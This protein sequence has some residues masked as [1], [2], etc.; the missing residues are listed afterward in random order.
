MNLLEEIISRKKEEIDKKRIDFPISELIKTEEFKKPTKSLGQ[1][2]TSGSGIIAE[3]KHKSPTAGI[4]DNGLGLNDVLDIYRMNEV[5]GVS[6]L[7]DEHYFGGSLE[8]LKTAAAFEVGPVLRKDFIVDEYQIFEAKAYGAD[9]ILLIAEAL[10]EYHATY[11]TTIAKSIGLEV[12]MEFHSAEELSKLNENVDVVGIN[13]RNLKTLKTDIRTAF[14]LVK[15][16]PYESIK[17]AESGISSTYEIQELLKVGYNGF[18]IGESIL[19]NQGLLQGF[20][21]AVEQF[22][23][24]RH[25]G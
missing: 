17:I 18:L 9:A 24:V 25:E 19:K 3:F 15:Q 10:D 13:N 11:L 5:S 23:N 2:I 14:E 7:T 21:Q 22:K 8:D 16:L 1:S 20:N 12:L 4:I 6:I